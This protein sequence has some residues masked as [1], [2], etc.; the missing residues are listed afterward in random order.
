MRDITGEGNPTPNGITP[1]PACMPGRHWPWLLLMALIGTA[2]CL[3]F[4]QSV[5][6]VGDEGVLL[7][8]AQRLLQGDRLYVDCFEFLPPGGFLLSAAWLSITGLSIQAARLLVMLTVTGIACFT[9][10]A[11]WQASRNRALAALLAGGWVLTTQGSQ[12]QLSHHWFTTLFAMIAAWAALAERETPQPPRYLA[13]I[14]GGGGRCG[15]DGNPHTG[16]TR[17]NC[18]RGVLYFIKTKKNNLTYVVFSGVSAGPCHLLLL[19]G[20]QRI[21]DERL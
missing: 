15:F 18:L 14:A 10:L 19:A 21:T 6:W 7:H 13:W 3:P 20:Y 9:Y 8:G 1:A 11:C 5:T 12:T 17:L 16:R 2:S 4:L